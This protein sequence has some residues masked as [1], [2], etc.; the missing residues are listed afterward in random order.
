MK[1]INNGRKLLFARVFVGLIIFVLTV[2]ESRHVAMSQDK[3]IEVITAEDKFEIIESS[4]KHAILD[5]NFKEQKFIPIS[6]ENIEPELQPKLSKLNLIPSKPI[7]L[8]SLEKIR[9]KADRE[10]NFTYLWFSPLKNANDRIT[11]TVGNCSA[12]K[13]EDSCYGNYSVIEY[14]RAGTAWTGDLKNGG[15]L[16]L[17]GLRY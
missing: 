3:G 4:L 15:F 11:L 9:Q 12:I 13:G 1:G 17:T 7:V 8:L 6:T 14:H 16:N 10:G 5:E 2:S